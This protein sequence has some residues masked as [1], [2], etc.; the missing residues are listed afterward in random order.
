MPTYLIFRKQ[1][2]S[3]NIRKASDLEALKAR[4][5][6]DLVALPCMHATLDPRSP[7]PFRDGAAPGCA[8]CS[9]R[10]RRSCDQTNLC[11]LFS[12]TAGQSN[13]DRGTREAS[14]T[15]EKGSEAQLVVH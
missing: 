3:E 6:W 8:D 4:V 2:D 10:N 5:R 13:V 14:E 11:R 9:R 12:V 7:I 1:L 15:A